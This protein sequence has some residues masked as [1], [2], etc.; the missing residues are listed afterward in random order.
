[1][2]FFLHFEACFLNQWLSRWSTPS[3][4]E[5]HDEDDEEDEEQNLGDLHRRAFQS[6][7]AKDAGHQRNDEKQ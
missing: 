7:E 2:E 6:P 5:G 3:Q 1:M 4:H